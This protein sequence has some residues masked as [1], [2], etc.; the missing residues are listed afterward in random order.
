MEVRDRERE[1]GWE[2]ESGR[3]REGPEKSE[4]REI[5]SGRERVINR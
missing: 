2:G 3:E 5:G 4:I 1:R